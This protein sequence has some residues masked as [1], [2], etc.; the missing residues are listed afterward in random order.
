VSEREPEE[1]TCYDMLSGSRP[2]NRMRQRDAAAVAPQLYGASG[3]R[4][5]RTRADECPM[6]IGS[7]SHASSVS[8]ATSR[9]GET[10][11]TNLYADT[12]SGGVSADPRQCR[13][14]CDSDG[15]PAASTNAFNALATAP[16]SS[17]IVP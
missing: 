9:F 7:S 17:M 3:K 14:H 1:K 8:A 16:G 13:H 15:S 11:D 6:L 12:A 10:I 5:V 2:G 4:A